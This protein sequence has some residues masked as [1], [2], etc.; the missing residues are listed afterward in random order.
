MRKLFIAAF[1]LLTLSALGQTTDTSNMTISSASWGVGINAVDNVIFWSDGK[2]EIRNGA[3]TLKAFRQL[4]EFSNKMER[5]YWE[6]KAVLE[7]LNLNYLADLLKDKYFTQ[8]VRKYQKS[9][10]TD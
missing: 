2:I 5:K 10:K 1:V 8:A 6:A 7:C 9:E 3:D 4:Y